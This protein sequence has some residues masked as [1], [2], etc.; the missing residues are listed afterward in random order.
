LQI[1]PNLRG[2]ERAIEEEMT[3]TSLGTTIP[4]L[5]H[6]HRRHSALLQ[7]GTGSATCRFVSSGKKFNHPL[8]TA[9]VPSVRSNASVGFEMETSRRS[10]Y[11]LLD[12]SREVSTEEVKRAYRR[13]ALRYFYINICDMIFIP[14]YLVTE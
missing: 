14:V 6:H 9:R 4:P 11:D 10:F 2:R 7:P 1:I 12:V 8:R 13:L 5:H 3:S